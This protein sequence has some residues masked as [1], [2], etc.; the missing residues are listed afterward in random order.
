MRGK[1]KIQDNRDRNHGE[2]MEGVEFTVDATHGE[3]GRQMASPVLSAIGP[4]QSF[5]FEFSSAD[6]ARQLGERL[7]ALARKAEDQTGNRGPE[8]RARLA[9]EEA[10]AELRGLIERLEVNVERLSPEGS[11]FS[12]S[13]SDVLSRLKM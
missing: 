11:T 9:R 12:A 1:G 13:T 5:Y 4:D 3:Y 2:I 10:M 7:I 8:Y 6:Q